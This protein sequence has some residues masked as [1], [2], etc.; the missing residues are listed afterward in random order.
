MTIAEPT[1][2]VLAFHRATLTLKGLPAEPNPGL[3]D[4]KWDKRSLCWRA[5]ARRYRELVTHLRERGIKYRDEARSYGVLDFPQR[6][7][8]TPRPYQS[9]ALQAWQDNGCRGVVVLPTGAGKT[10]L[11]VLAMAAARRP[12]LIHVPTID[13]LLQWHSVLGKFFDMPIGRLGGGFSDIEA[14]TVSTYDSMLIH[15]DRIGNRFGT[16]IFDE[17]HRLPGDQYQ[18]LALGNIAPFRLGL[19]ATPERSDGR[20]AQ[21]Y[22]LCGD[23]VYRAFIH[24]LT[25]Y[26]LAPYEVETVEVEMDSDERDAYEAA[27]AEYIEFLRGSQI[28]LRQPNGWVKFIWQAGKTPHGRAALRAYQ[29]QKKLSLASRAKRDVLWQILQRHVDDRIIVFTQDNESAYDLGRLFYLPVLTHQTKAKERAAF[30]DAFRSGRFRVLVT[31]KVLN[32][33][34]DVPDANVAVVVSG[35]GSVRE[36]VQRLGRILRARPGKTAVLYE[37]VAKDTR[38][39]FVNQRRKKHHAY[40][41]PDSL[42]QHQG[43]DQTDLDQEEG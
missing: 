14:V 34:V 11:A 41:G 33:G 30:L 29:T 7:N 6:E 35:S 2:P 38:E 15:L 42:S 37:L 23:N 40:Q 1:I 32:E 27:Y 43:R 8:L 22:E 12:T 26:T 10:I 39:Y 25:G 9:E 3:P 16:I 24:D 21:L 36:H 28:D 5:P 17:C 13:L 4:L 18:F 31:S 19:T 20:E